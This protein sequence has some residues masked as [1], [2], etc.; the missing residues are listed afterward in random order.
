MALLRVEGLEKAFGGVMAVAD[1]SFEVPEGSV[2]A[3]IGPNGAGKTTL[4]NM[5][6]GVYTPTAGRIEF[7]GRRIDGLPPHR[8]ARLGIA[9]TFQNLQVFFNM[10]VLENV[11]VGCHLRGRTGLVAAALRLPRILREERQMRAWAEEALA[12]C[13]LEAYAGREA[14]A[15]PYGILK[16]L[17][18]ARALAAQPRMLLMD[19]PAAGLNDTETLE[20]RGLIRRI[21]ERGVTV[22]LVEHNMGL[23]M[24][25]SDTVLVLDYGRRLTEGSPEQVQNDPEVIAAYLGGE[26]EY[27]VS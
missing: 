4:F 1:L 18:I 15:L 5:L 23:V 21:C 3:V 6:S 13:G 11:M 14:A 12:F 10:T 26:V 8:V 16:R 17:E 9:R 7:A 24:E 20:M 22:L 2:Y 19:E 27:A 25:V